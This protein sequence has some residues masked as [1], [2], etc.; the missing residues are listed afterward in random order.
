MMIS[1][2][3]EV[4]R[5]NLVE[6]NILE[7]LFTLLLVAAVSAFCFAISFLL[8]RHWER[9]RKWDAIQRR[10]LRWAPPFARKYEKV[11]GGVADTVNKYVTVSLFAAVAVVVGIGL[12]RGL[13]LGP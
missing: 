8:Y 13:F 12:I 3:G 5:L 2:I 1:V 6:E 10:L 9:L 4:C 11:Q 7:Y